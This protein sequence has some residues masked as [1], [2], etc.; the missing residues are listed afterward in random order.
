MKRIRKQIRG[1]EII[2]YLVCDKFDRLIGNEVHAAEDILEGQLENALKQMLLNKNFNKIF[3]IP[4]EIDVSYY[5]VFTQAIDAMPKMRFIYLTTLFDG[6]VHEYIAERSGIV[7]KPNIS[8]KSLVYSN[9][10]KEWKENTKESD[11]L[12][13]VKFVDYLFKKLYS[14]DFG[15]SINCLT[16]EM[17]DVRNNIVHN[18]GLVPESYRE[19][20]KN[21]FQYLNITHNTAITITK[22]L[23][24][25]YLKDIRKI[26]S[27]CN[28][29][30][31]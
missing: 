24:Q 1:G 16:L 14:I 30:G 23:M 15:K 31:P 17:G 3:N 25:I 26:I 6:F 7:Y 11:S 13:H 2:S 9:I 27:I 4:M 8:L 12:Y 18:N 22:P 29:V 19:Q 28:E 21:T 5:E 10:A 20:L